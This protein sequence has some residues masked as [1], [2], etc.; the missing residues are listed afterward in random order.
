MNDFH[1]FKSPKRLSAISL[2][3]VLFVPAFADLLPA[4][5]VQLKPH[6]TEAQSDSALEFWWLEGSNKALRASALAAGLQQLFSSQRMVVDRNTQKLRPLR[7]RDVAV[8]NRLK[9]KIGA[10]RKIGLAHFH[11]RQ[12]AFERFHRE[13]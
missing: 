3:F 12:V 5:Q 4:E 10:K 8:L 13:H 9:D 11:L 2:F 1:R 7:F 6:R